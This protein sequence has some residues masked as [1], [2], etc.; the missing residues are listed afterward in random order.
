MT[1]M[2]TLP[3]SKSISVRRI[4]ILENRVVT[5]ETS[6]INDVTL[7]LNLSALSRMETYGLNW[8]NVDEYCKKVIHIV[9][10]LDWI[11]LKTKGF[12]RLSTVWLALAG[13]KKFVYLN[14]LGILKCFR[15]NCY[16]PQS[17]C[18]EFVES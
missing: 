18:S 12:S 5:L 1:V 7:Y 2:F 11:L 3:A 16:V 10:L 4:N 8:I 14:K 15:M 13:D 17:F 9:K 6:G